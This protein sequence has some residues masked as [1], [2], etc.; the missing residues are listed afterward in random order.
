MPRTIQTNPKFVISQPRAPSKKPKRAGKR[1][2][3]G[4]ECRRCTEVVGSDLVQCSECGINELSP[5]A[6]LDN[7]K[8]VYKKHRRTS[9]A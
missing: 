1:T 3:K 5:C 8:E 9:N 4:D 6:G 2:V 7:A